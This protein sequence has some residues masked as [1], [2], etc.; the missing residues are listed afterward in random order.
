MRSKSDLQRIRND[1]LI[2]SSPVNY[3]C[4][5]CKYTG[6]YPWTFTSFQAIKHHYN[7]NRDSHKKSL[8]QTCVRTKNL[9]SSDTEPVKVS[10][11]QQ[12]SIDQFVMST[13]SKTKSSEASSSSHDNQQFV[14]FTQREPAT[15]NSGSSN[16]QE[17]TTTPS[18]VQDSNLNLD[19]I[20]FNENIGDS[21]DQMD[22]E[23][24]NQQEES[25]NPSQPVDRSTPNSGPSGSDNAAAKDNFETLLDQIIDG[26]TIRSKT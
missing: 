20:D 18:N 14:P 15:E 5:T 11:L 7:S 4:N 19:D 6:K 12:R 8:Q 13:R 25:S 23:L 16:N 24:V 17:R 3:T 9:G 21:D 10:T 2:N 22:T 26:D 1:P